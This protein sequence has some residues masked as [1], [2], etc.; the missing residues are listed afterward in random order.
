MGVGQ[1]DETSK[2]RAFRLNRRHFILTKNAER[3]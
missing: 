3:M 2:K 1:Y